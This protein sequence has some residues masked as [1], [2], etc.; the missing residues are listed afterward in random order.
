MHL[1]VPNNMFHPAAMGLVNPPIGPIFGM[2]YPIRP[3]LRPDIQQGQNPPSLMQTHTQTDNSGS[4]AIPVPLGHGQS[5]VSISIEQGNPQR[6]GVQQTPPLQHNPSEGRVQTD[7]CPPRCAQGK[8]CDAGICKTGVRT[9]SQVK[10]VASQPSSTSQQRSQRSQQ[11][12]RS[13]TPKG[14]NSCRPPCASIDVCIAGDCVTVQFGLRTGAIRRK[15]KLDYP[16][17]TGNENVERAIRAQQNTLEFFPL[18]STSLWLSG[19]YF[20]QVPAGLAG[21]FYLYGRNKYFEGYLESADRRQNTLEF[22][23]IFSTSF[24]LAGVYLHQV[25]VSIVGLFYI[26]AREKYYNGYCESVDGRLPG[27]RYSVKALKALIIMFGIGFTDYILKEF[28]GIDLKQ[29]ALKHLPI[30]F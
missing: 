27:F 24:W 19:I 18:F 16:A 21:L 3:P 10:P 2:Q 15:Y 26:Y 17:M 11:D 14:D 12:Q 28:A 9:P 20:H 4:I 30:K 1:G 25:P 22:F 7:E 8:Y 29:E 23:P 5:S 13:Q 6:T